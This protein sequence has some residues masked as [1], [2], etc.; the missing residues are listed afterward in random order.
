MN[1]KRSIIFYCICYY[2]LCPSSY[3]RLICYSLSE[4]CLSSWYESI[5]SYLKKQ[6][7]RLCVCTFLS[8]FQ[9]DPHSNIQQLGRIKTLISHVVVEYNYGYK[10]Y[11]IGFSCSMLPKK[12]QYNFFLR[13]KYTFGISC[14]VL[15]FC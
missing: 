9:L 12:I 6:K 11:H 1:S 15:L 14:Y 4:Y 2:N 7:K 5:Q 13:D 10:S 8:L 3:A